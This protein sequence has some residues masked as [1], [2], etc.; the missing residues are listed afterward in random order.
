M[1]EGVIWFLILAAALEGASLFQARLLYLRWIR[2]RGLPDMGPVPAWPWA[3]AL[4]LLPLACLQAPDRGVARGT[5]YSVAGADPGARF[6]LLP[7][8]GGLLP[9]GILVDTTRSSGEACCATLRVPMGLFGEERHLPFGIPAL[10][11]RF[12]WE[13]LARPEGDPD[14]PAV[15]IAA[16]QQGSVSPEGRQELQT[17]WTRHLFLEGG[18]KGQADVPM[19]LLPPGQRLPG[20]RVA[21]FGPLVLVP[22]GWKV[23]FRGWE[24][25][26]AAAEE[27]EPPDPE[28][29]RRFVAWYGRRQ[30]ASSQADFHWRGRP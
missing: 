29:G 17:F 25:L 26:P 24:A 22:P 10:R 21:L 20:A 27:M 30:V 4:P 14:P 12:Q 9:D 8:A 18:E 1:A 23:A 16:S 3:L 13:I 28:E 7:E 19:R 11:I 2:R 15:K 6:S 5:P